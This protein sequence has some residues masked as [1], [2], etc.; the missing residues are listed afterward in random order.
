MNAKKLFIPFIIASTAIGLL[1]YAF[2]QHQQHCN[3]C[4]SLRLFTPEVIK[5]YIEGFGPL[6]IVVYILLYAVN[7]V[8]LLPPIAIMS[9]SAGF[10]F[11]PV[12]GTIALTL[13]AFLGTSITFFI[14]RFFG[15]KLVEKL[16]KGKAAEFQEK[17]EKNGFMVILPI[18]LIGFPPWEVVNYVSGLSKIKY[19][20]YISATMLGIFP[21]IIIQVFFSDRLSNLN[22]KDPTL[23]V[24]VGAFVLLA[25]V[26]TMYL[27]AKKK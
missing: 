23:Y 3:Y 27:R 9:L 8:S 11:G 7:T 15:G 6:A 25:V 22:L 17:L 4:I 14:A 18:R 5:H 12:K 13:G 26:P 1:G 10:L 16:S 21:A 24:A 2:Y 19:R 20:D